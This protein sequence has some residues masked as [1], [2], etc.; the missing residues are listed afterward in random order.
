MSHSLGRKLLEV[1]WIF[2]I[3]SSSLGNCHSTLLQFEFTFFAGW[4]AVFVFLKNFAKDN[5]QQK[6]EK[7]RESFRE[8]LSE[9]Q[10]R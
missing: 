10:E 9:W 2:T 4:V 1:K 3:R 7:K 8:R 5:L 6:P